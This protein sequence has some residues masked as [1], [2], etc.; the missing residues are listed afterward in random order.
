MKNFAGREDT[1]FTVQ[2]DFVGPKRFNLTY[3]DKDQAEKEAIVI[4]RSSIGAIERTM[5]FLIEH[6]TGAFP[7]WL[8]PVQAVVIPVADRHIEYAV[9]LEAEM[10]KAGIR[11]NVD[12]RSERINQKIRN[13]QL[14]KIPYMLVVGDKEEADSTVSVR[15]RTGEQ[16]PAQSIDSFIENVIKIISEKSLKLI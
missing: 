3:I 1:V 10:K 11:V 9:R 8:S 6:Y 16:L 14:E 5:A 7:V 15:L 12:D 4:H 13:A 2:Y